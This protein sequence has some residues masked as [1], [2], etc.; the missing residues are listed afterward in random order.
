M[1]LNSALFVAFLCVVCAISY[2]VPRKFRYVWL[3]LTSYAFYLYN[4]AGYTA[5]LLELTQGLPPEFTASLL[6]GLPAVGLLA[7]A[8]IVS[9]GCGLGMQHAKKKPVKRLWMILSLCMCLGVLFASKY[10]NFFLSAVPLLGGRAITVNFILPLGISYYTLQTV[11]Y[12]VDVYT[13]AMQAVRN[14]F[15]YALFVSFFPG[16]VVGPINRAQEMIPQYR[17]PNRFS[18]NTVAGG[19]FRVLWGIFKKMVIADN[20]AVFTSAVF[21]MPKAHRGPEVVLAALLF[22]YQLYMDFSGSTD[23]AIGAARMFG[24]TFMENFERPF[25]AKTFPGLWQRW[26]KSLTSFLRDYVFTP[27]VWSRWTEKLPIIG[28]KVQKPPMLLSTVLIFILSGLWHGANISYV[29]WGLANGVI[30]V[31]AQ[32]FGKKK[33]KLV[34]KIPVYRIRY[35]RGFF[36]RVFVYLLFTACI[37]FF[38]AALFGTST[39]VVL[40]SMAHG[41]DVLG[42]GFGGVLAASGLTSKILLA[43]SGAVLLVELTEKFGITEKTNMADW[44]RARWFFVRWPLYYLLAAALLFF[45]AFGQSIFIYQ[46]Y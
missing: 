45:G 46:R 26:H 16:I 33:N 18:Y 2:A 4:S 13:G 43:L 7:G 38:A 3:L 39:T 11:A 19:L 21:G 25:A 20:L 29:F 23:I 15:L 42:T 5:E 37:V 31:L 8:T 17:R 44:I 27:L 40:S 10:L 32:M 35:V 34:N 36:Q 14:P 24:F 30:M 9:F 41:W 1:A 12:T 6:K 22:S 28:K